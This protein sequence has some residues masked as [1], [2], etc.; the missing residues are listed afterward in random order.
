MANDP[1]KR[2]RVE[3]TILGGVCSEVQLFDHDQPV[4]FDLEIDD[5]DILDLSEEH[6]VEEEGIPGN[7]S[8]QAPPA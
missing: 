4:E 7:C 1:P 8:G 3:V 5:Q 2:F 6:E